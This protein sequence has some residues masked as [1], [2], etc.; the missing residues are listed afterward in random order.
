MTLIDGSYWV[1]EYD[2][3][4]QVKSGKRYW[5][6]GT[7][8]AG[9]Q[10]EYGHD[11]IGNRTT[12]AVGGDQNGSNLRSASYV[13][14]SKNQYT[15]RG[16]PPY[17]E[18]LGIATVDA[19]VTV[20]GSSSGVYRHGEYFR[21]ELNVN[22]AS[23]AQYPT[24]DV[25]TDVTSP[26]SGEKFLPLHPES[27]T[28]DADGNLTQDG[29]WDYVWD[30]ENRL[31]KMR[32]RS[33]SP[34]PERRIEFEYDW[35]GRRIRQTVWNDR[36]DG[37][38]SELSDTLYLY[39]GWNLIAELNANSSNAKVRTYIWG[40]DLSGLMQGAG[41]VGGLLMVIDHTSAKRY[42]T[43]YDGN[44][45]VMGLADSTT[46]KWSAR[47]EYGPF[48]EVIRANGPASRLNPFRF[49]TKYQDDETDLLYYGYRYYTASTGRWIS[50]DPIQERG[51]VALYAFA[52][53]NP[54]SVVDFFG[55]SFKIIPQT[56]P[57]GTLPTDKGRDVLGRTWITKRELIKFSATTE[58]IT[59]AYC[60][61]L[62][63]DK[64]YEVE[65]TSIKPSSIPTGFTEN[66]FHLIESHEDR[67]AQVY[68]RAHD[69]YYEPVKGI[70]DGKYL[71]CSEPFSAVVLLN[72][73]LDVAKAYE[74]AF[75][76]YAKSQNDLIETETEDTN[77][78]PNKDGLIDGLFYIYTPGEMPGVGA[79]PPEPNCCDAR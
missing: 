6:D 5:S 11:T 64:D 10:F 17:I 18:V 51:G 47:Y 43:A 7:P 9:Q 32:S 22:N 15:S 79:L 13:V 45:N 39:D 37:Q 26:V 38:G 35:Q 24:I 66:G 70:I 50:R 23:A 36:D 29:R 68:S 28:P 76:K 52:H 67:R 3:L 25:D 56:A 21:K 33:G 48:G 27:F 71:C 60:V 31:S 54:I 4:G 58:K 78:I 30:G 20:E 63:V 53:N 61:T 77:L 55:L 42:F 1:Y 40:L 57:P 14:N 62:H 72:W 44:G 41:G 16:V 34:A 49:S 75:D 65:V 74:A 69:A 19:T 2:A 46:G 12:T 59:C 8:V 73:A